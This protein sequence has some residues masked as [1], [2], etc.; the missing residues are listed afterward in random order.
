MLGGKSTAKTAR[1]IA[2]SVRS[3]V[4][5]IFDMAGHSVGRPLVAAARTPDLFNRAKHLFD[6]AKV[7]PRRPLRF[8][9][10]DRFDPRL[11]HLCI[12][13][14]AGNVTATANDRAGRR[15]PCPKAVGLAR[16]RSRISGAGPRDAARSGAPRL[17]SSAFLSASA[18][19]MRNMIVQGDL[20]RELGVTED[21]LQWLAQT[22]RLPSA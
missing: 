5:R 14:V 10:R 15:V 7:V 1:R 4:F 22:H 13:P 9:A 11:R 17:A 19:R 20:A 21:A 18:G 12:A 2:R 8:S 6:S 16:S 3:I